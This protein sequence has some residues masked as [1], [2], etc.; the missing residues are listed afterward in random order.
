[1]LGVLLRFHERP[2][3]L[4]GH[5]KEMYYSMKISELDQHTHRF[6]WQ[7]MDNNKE[8]DTYVVTTVSFVYKPDRNIATLALRKTAKI[9]EKCFHKH[10]K[11]S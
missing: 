7:D 8:V 11:W 5:F 10:R 4:T 9:E 1:M 6:L 2:V 3:A